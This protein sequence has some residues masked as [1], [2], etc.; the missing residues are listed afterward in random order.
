VPPPRADDDAGP[1]RRGGFGFRGSQQASRYFD[2]SGFGL[3]LTDQAHGAVALDLLQLVRIHQAVAAGWIGRLSSERPEHGNH[4]RSRHH[5]KND[6]KRHYSKRLNFEA[7][8]SNIPA[9]KSANLFAPSTALRG[10]I[11]P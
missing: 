1:L 8:R 10:Y 2:P 7:T 3:R 9:A 4:C 11:T 5:G 6:P